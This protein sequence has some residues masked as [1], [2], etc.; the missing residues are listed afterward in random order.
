MIPIRAGRLHLPSARSIPG[1]ET[2]EPILLVSTRSAIG[3]GRERV[4]LY[5]TFEVDGL[6]LRDTIPLEQIEGTLVG[7][8]RILKEELARP[9]KILSR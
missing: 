2:P 3:C 4:H 7:E 1:G 9:K 6:F 5:V 8:S